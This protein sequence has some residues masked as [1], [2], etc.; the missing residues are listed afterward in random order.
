V[1]KKVD[2]IFNLARTSGSFGS[3]PAEVSPS[4]NYDYHFTM[5]IRK[6]YLYTSAKVCP[7]F[8]ST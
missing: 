3:E 8:F 4:A 2:V 1:V 6:T 7:I 5:N